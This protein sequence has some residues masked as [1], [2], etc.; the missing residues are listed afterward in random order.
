MPNF[1]IIILNRGIEN[2]FNCKVQIPEMFCPSNYVANEKN[3]YFN[4][5]GVVSHF[6]ESG[7]GCHFI[8]FCKHNID[9]KWRYYNDSIVNECQN[10]FLQKGTPY[11]LFYQKEEIFGNSFQNNNNNIDKNIN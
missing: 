5:I 9:G 1:L 11:I 4:L 3:S 10:D 8:A 6:G 2:I 7:M